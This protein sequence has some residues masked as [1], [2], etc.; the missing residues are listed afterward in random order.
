MSH[1]ISWIKYFIGILFF[2]IT[3]WTCDFVPR[4]VGDKYVI[5]GFP[6]DTN[7]D[8]FLGIGFSFMNR[9][10]TSGLIKKEWMFWPMSWIFRALHMLPV[11]R[12]SKHQMIFQIANEFSKRDQFFPAISPEGTRKKV[13]RIQ[14]G[15]WDIAHKARV[16]ILLLYK[17]S[18]KKRVMVLGFLNPGESKKDDLLIIRDIYRQAGYEIPLQSN[19]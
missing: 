6:H 10:Q 18:P 9:I 13:N 2:K 14:T 12:F 1:L 15:F 19:L 7:F 11:D 5:I 8:A 16:P 4:E 17:N 3:G